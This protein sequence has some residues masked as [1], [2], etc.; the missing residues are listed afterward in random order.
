MA[1]QDHYKVL[2]VPREASAADVKK[3]YRK[4]ARLHHPDM[5]QAADAA[6]RM[7]ELNEAYA[8]LSDAAKRAEFDAIGQAPL[9]GDRFTP[10][11]GWNEGF[12]FNGRG[13]PPGD[14][15][16]SAFF[17]SLFGQAGTPGRRSHAS[18]RAVRGEDLHASIQLDIEDAWQGVRRT[19]TLQSPTTDAQGHPK[20]AERT[21][22]V[23]IPPGVKAGQSIRLAGQGSPGGGGGPAGDMLLEVHLRP[24]ARYRLEGTDLHMALPLSPWEAALGAVVP[25]SLPG[26]QSLKVRVPAGT[27]G[28]Q[29]ITVR[30]RGWPAR[31]PGDLDLT[32]AVVLPS[33]SEPAVRALY[34]QMAA[35]LP[36]FDA[37]KPQA[38]APQAH[39]HPTAV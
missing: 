15:D 5:S 37:R 31:K 8:V 27:Q 14:G 18:A 9:H 3:A 19:I 24:H 7:S 4:L 34:E 30:G 29:V 6:E 36:A 17:E 11:P 28:G 39:K 25:V 33:A 26:G 35:A 22:E 23:G 2:G 38:A 10:P 12:T 32:V 21:L 16:H 1:T 20:W 13:M